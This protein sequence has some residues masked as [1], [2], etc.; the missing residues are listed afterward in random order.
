[1]YISQ[2]YEKV[3]PLDV[4]ALGRQQ[5]RKEPLREGISVQQLVG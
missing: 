2:I 5:P 3:A 4:R 1:M